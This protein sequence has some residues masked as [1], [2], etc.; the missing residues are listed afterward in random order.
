MGCQVPTSGFAFNSF[1]SGGNVPDGSYTYKITYLYY[2]FEE[3][4]GALETGTITV[5]SPNSTVRFDI[6]VGGY[7][8][9]ARKIY[10]TVLGASNFILAGTVTTP[11]ATSFDEYQ[12]AGTFPIPVLNALPPT[13]QNIN[14]YLDR[15]F[16]SGVAGA[17]YVL[18][19]SDVGLPD[20]F[21][22]RNFLRCNQEDP[23]VTH[24]VFKGRLIILNRQSLGQVLGRSR[25]QFRYD[26]IPDAVGC[27]DARSVQVRTVQ[28]IPLLIWLSD[29]GFYA[30]NG[31]SV[32]YISE[33]IEDLVNFN[34]QQAQFTK[35]KNAQT[36]QQDFQNGTPGPGVDLTITP[37]SITSKNPK[38]LW[39]DILDW[40]GGETKEN[41][42]TK[43]GDNKLKAPIRFAPSLEDGVSSG[44]STDEIDPLT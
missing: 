34:I 36:S 31:N 11:T 18:Q 27:V 35:G 17:P 10:R 29:K 30:Y 33:D 7:G 14:L 15:S 3:S 39:D 1:Q 21:P 43:V 8:V 32:N 9:T 38:Q 16:I 42:V 28:G 4:N 19:F 24:V 12:A 20:I 13:F 22:S 40:D 6:P 37:G 2:G 26:P 5:A 41:V 25:F 44:A 23:I